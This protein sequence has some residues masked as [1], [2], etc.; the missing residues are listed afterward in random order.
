[1]SVVVRRPLGRSS[2]LQNRAVAEKK[3]SDKGFRRG[4]VGR[5]PPFELFLLCRRV[6]GMI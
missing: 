6:Q 3:P 4:N 1:M 5:N 2:S